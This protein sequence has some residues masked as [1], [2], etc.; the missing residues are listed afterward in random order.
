MKYTEFNQIRRYEIN[1]TANGDA[2]LIEMPPQML[3]LSLNLV[4]LDT[5]SGLSSGNLTWYS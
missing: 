4:E 5:V 3:I 2:P 1:I